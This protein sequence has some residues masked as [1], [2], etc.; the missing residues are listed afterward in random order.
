MRDNFHA[1]VNATWY[2]VL[3]D[4]KLTKLFSIKNFSGA[5]HAGK[6]LIIII[7][8]SITDNDALHLHSC[9]LIAGSNAVM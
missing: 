7:L 1:G 8:F 4:H 5:K 3:F 6:V 9:T 2:S